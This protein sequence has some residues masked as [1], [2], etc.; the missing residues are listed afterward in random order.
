MK[1]IKIFLKKQNIIIKHFL[2]NNKI[3]FDT[4]FQISV[5]IISIFLVIQSNAILK[6]QLLTETKEVA[7]SF[8]FNFKINK[9]DYITYHLH[10]NKGYISNVNFEKFNVIIIL[11]KI[12]SFEFEIF[13]TYSQTTSKQ[14]DWYFTTKYKENYYDEIISKI[15]DW[16]N[17]QKNFFIFVSYDSL[18]KVKYADYQNKYYED[19]FYINSDGSGEYIT[20]YNSQPNETLTKYYIHINSNEDDSNK[21][22]NIIIE[23]LKFH[24]EKNN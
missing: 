23:Y 11:S 15:N 5:S 4:I 22:A 13:D 20:N 17:K 3:Y 7:P 9:N 10:N 6:L 21:I 16:T 2:K 8:N 18:Y 24:Y 19:Y 14:N 1:S 12:G